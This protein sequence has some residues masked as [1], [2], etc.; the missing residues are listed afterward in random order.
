MYLRVHVRVLSLPSQRAPITS[1]AAKSSFIFSVDIEEGSAKLNG[2]Y[3]PQQLSFTL[4]PGQGNFDFDVSLVN[5]EVIEK[6]ETFV[7]RFDKLGSQQITLAPFDSTTVS[8]L[9]DDGKLCQFICL[10]NCL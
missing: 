6:N 3:F 9:D 10:G 7:A 4:Q 8:I 1:H 5:D 2:D